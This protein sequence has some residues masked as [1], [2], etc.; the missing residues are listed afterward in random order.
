MKVLNEKDL[1]SLGLDPANK[2]AC[3][4]AGYVEELPGLFL[5]QADHARVEH[6]YPYIE[7]DGYLSIHKVLGQIG[8]LNSPSLIHTCVSS[9]NK[10]FTVETLSHK[11]IRF[12][13]M[14]L[15]LMPDHFRDHLC[16][17][18]LERGIRS[19][20][21]ERAL[22]DWIILSNSGHIKSPP[23]DIDIEQIDLARLAAVADEL[24]V[25]RGL[26]DYLDYAASMGYGEEEFK[27]TSKIMKY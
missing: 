3:K 26:M 24:G 2:L 16:A 22:C 25:K 5:N 7:P 1:R 23:V 21:P 12:Y 27:P 18:M 14:E 9:K 13:P 19:A 17:R 6:L 4:E 10:V 8:F 15:S 20:T 11:L